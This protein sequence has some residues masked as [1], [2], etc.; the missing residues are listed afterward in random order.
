MTEIKNSISYTDIGKRA[1]NEDSYVESSCFFIV[2]DGV[3]GAEKGEIASNIVSEVFNK[4]FSQN[5]DASSEDVLRIAE[6]KLSEHIESYP[7]SMGMATT[8]TFSKI[9]NDGLLV[10]WVG[11]SRIYQFRNGKIIFQT[12]DHSWV[13][14]AVKAGI[15]TPEEAVDHPKSNII[16]RAIQGN[17]KPVEIDVE[18]IEDVCDDD[19]I[20]HC[21]DG[22]L[23]AW[24][25]EELEALFSET[26]D[27]KSI[28]LKIET[29]CSELSR[30]NN[31]AILYQI[32][33]DRISKVVDETSAIETIQEEN[34]VEAIPL[35]ENELNNLTSNQNRFTKEDVINHK[36]PPIRKFNIKL[37]IGSIFAI[38]IVFSL[39]SVLSGGDDKKNKVDTTL[40]K[41]DEKENSQKRRNNLTE[42]SINR[43][44]I[45]EPTTT[46]INTSSAE[47]NEKI[48]E[49]EVIKKD[50]INKGHKSTVKAQELVNK[51]AKTKDSKKE[52]NQ[53]D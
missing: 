52:K 15:L 4:E 37:L 6:L 47:S 5:F 39:K 29:K 30:D 8:L 11:D 19:F 51:L 2:C 31:T 53:N 43:N 1:N 3:G 41:G 16:T 13:N 14:E 9:L 18:L 12:E 45:G 49:K 22:V 46:K 27:L 50:T 21:S 10:A 7:D 38:I 25:N 34:V 44:K 23:E 33:S 48:E 35:T 26:T 42:N 28:L 20:F 32:K 40:S 24:T 17:H 36:T